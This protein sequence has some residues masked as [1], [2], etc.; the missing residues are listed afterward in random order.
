MI[1]SSILQTDYL[2]LFVGFISVILCKLGRIPLIQLIKSLKPFLFLFLFTFFFHFFFTP[3]RPISLFLG[4][5]ELSYEGLQQGIIINL[6]LIN[7]IWL[8]SIATFTTSPKQM[9]N[10]MESFLR[11]L[12]ALNFP[13][14]NFSLM[15]L[16]SMKFIPIIF[17]EI[18]KVNFSFQNQNSKNM[19]WSFHSIINET[20]SIISP[21]LVNS[22]RRADELAK[23]IDSFGFEVIDKL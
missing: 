3:G 10:T 2:L 16:I 21:I 19:K 1:S 17:Q 20:V 5:I 9:V 4:A 6:R 18:N 14:K 12:K 23:E 13:V 15:M 11:P 8:S 7:L 22:F